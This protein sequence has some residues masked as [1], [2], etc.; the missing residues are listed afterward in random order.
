MTQQ[1][2]K[3]QESPSVPPPPPASSASEIGAILALR[4]EVVRE[5]G[6]GGMGVVYLCK[7]MVTN[8]R[9]ALKRLRSPEESKGAARTEE[10]WWFHQEARA[11]ASLDHPAVVRARD[12]GT[13]ADGSPYLVMDALPGR[14]VHEWM[15]TTTL[16]WSVIWA[17]VDQGLAGL[18][19]AHARGV[20]H[21]DLKPSNLMLDLASTS[22][23][24][25][26]Y[27]LDLGL[28]W[29]RQ[30]RHDSR[31]DGSPAPELAL[32]AGA[33]TV[34]W[35][36]PEQIRK[37]APHVGPATDLYALGC[38]VYRILT[39]KEVFEGNAQDV[40]R[41]HK[42]NPVPPPRLP[43]GV[44]MGVAHYVVRLLA[45]KP[46]QR[47]E[48]AADARR[49]WMLYRPAHA[50]TLEE[51]VTGPATSRPTAPTEPAAVVAARS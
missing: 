37:L 42:R 35:V 28:A 22:R 24:P 3:G 13:L 23:G 36:A 27:I 47:W 18:A 43:E 4:Y 49:A 30:Q 46:W 51:T 16:P 5:L 9:V 8:E 39:G 34:G 32:H 31:L 2:E 33:G 50:P 20:I 38:I 14:S 25:R 45:K 1:G 41:A 19:H 12:F 26:V 15:H 6:R 29:L 44:P 7:D 21:G 48:F 17:I 10:S 11:V 40:L